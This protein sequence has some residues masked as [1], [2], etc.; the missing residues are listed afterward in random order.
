MST[1]AKLVVGA[2]G[3]LG[4]HVVK[5]LVARGENVRVL[6][7]PTSST[8]AIDGLP[9]ER[10][11]GDIFDRDALR[12][13]MAGCDVVHYCVVDARPWL[14]D[15]SPMWRT[16]VVGLRHVLDIAV[17]AELRRFVFTSSAC[18]IGL[19]GRGNTASEQTAH[20][21]P[22]AGGDYVRSRVQAEEMVLHDSRWNGLPGVAM[23]VSNTYGAGDWLPTP[24]GG[25]VSDV[26][27][28]RMPFHIKGVASEVVG[29]E[30][31]ATALV[32][33]GEHGRV[34]ERY[35]VSE[36]FVSTRDIYETACSAVGAKPPRFGVPIQLMSAAARLNALIAGARGTDTRLTPLAMRL[37]GIMSP[38]D[39]GKAERDLGWR[40]RP[41]PEAIADA[42]R[43]FRAERGR[44]TDR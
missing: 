28:G 30:D 25:M 36:R 33:A 5:Q 14:R 24:H 4:S 39:H 31:A 9:V 12:A 6:L 20:N 26:I 1:A 44:R 37:M 19:A 40:P 38:M 21:W 32:L 42:A 13:A 35:I 2:S 22:T 3:F 29:V 16:N 18:T 34:G 27:R 10:H 41:A 7:R 11:Y 17:E 23:C 8:R 15:P 43:F